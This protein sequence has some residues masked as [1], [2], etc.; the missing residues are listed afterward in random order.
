MYLGV[1]V[2][3]Y[4]CLAL[5]H[6]ASQLNPVICHNCNGPTGCQPAMAMDDCSYLASTSV[7]LCQCLLEAHYDLC[8]PPAVMRSYSSDYLLTTSR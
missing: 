1:G 3:A 6:S 5:L 4:S 2:T 8:D 7:M